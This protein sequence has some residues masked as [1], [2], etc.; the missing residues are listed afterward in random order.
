M[1]YIHVKDLVKKIKILMVMRL[2]LVTIVMVAGSLVLEVDKTFFYSIIAIFYF[3]TFV[4]ALFLRFG[5]PLYINAYIQ[6]ITD[7]ILETVII[8][9]AGGSDSIYALL[10]VPSIV[11]SGI[12]ISSTGAKTIA[13]LSSVFYAAISGME[14]FGII[15]I[16]GVQITQNIQELMFI[17]SFRVIIFCLVGYLSSYLSKQLYEQRTELQKLRNLSDVILKN[18]S[19]GVLT[20]DSEAKIIYANTAAL[21]VFAKTSFELLNSKWENLFFKNVITENVKEFLARAKS[22][23]GTETEI[24][25]GDGKGIVL[26]C[27]YREMTD[28]KNIIIGSIITFV[29]ITLIKELEIE[30]RQREKLGAMGEMAV[31]IAHEIRNP[32]ASIR[33][34]LEVLREKGKLQEGEKLMDVVFKETDRLNRIVE[35]FLQYAKERK[36][37]IKNENIETLID[38]VWLLI[39]QDERWSGSVRLEK[40]LNPSK[41]MLNIDSDRMKQVFYNL[42]I[43]SLEAMP[44][45]GLIQ[46]FVEDGI[47]KAKITVRDTGLGI[48]KDELGS[49]FKN[50]H[51]TKS[52]GLGIGLKISKRIIE[53][54]HGTIELSSKEKEGTTAT[55]ILPKAF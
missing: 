44:Y 42:F 9:Y 4:Y 12:L 21:N 39:R 54:H 31:S 23:E 26:R 32:M 30:L 16:R 19:S 29:D 40:K 46:V 10:Y 3:A 2:V 22:G 20:L 28:E 8:H 11:A 50:F 41:I 52:G 14:Y 53:F 17:V 49:L 38:E 43:N 37:N 45:G 27:F 33:G 13:G 6:I 15:N 51:S 25:R 36:L 1:N 18:I 34:A 7:I 24:L 47:N 5:V 55:I 35:D 48:S